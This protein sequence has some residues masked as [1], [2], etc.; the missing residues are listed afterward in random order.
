MTTMTDVKDLIY[1]LVTLQDWTEEQLSEHSKAVEAA[2]ATLVPSDEQLE[3]RGIERREMEKEN[4]VRRWCSLTGCNR[5]LSPKLELVCALC[6]QT[7]CGSHRHMEN[8]ACTTREEQ[9]MWIELNKE[10]ARIAQAR[11]MNT[12][13][14]TT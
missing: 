11:L 3:L 4:G 13:T 5:S 12:R 14:R 8:H 9:Y 10:R 6:Q 1:P 7:F 2:I